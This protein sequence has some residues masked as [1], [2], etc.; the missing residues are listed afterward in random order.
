MTQ[1]AGGER[2]TGCGT[3]YYD[4]QCPLCSAEVRRLQQLGN[5]SLSLLD[6]HRLTDTGG[7]AEKT[8]LLKNLHYVTP[9]GEVLVGLDANVAAWQH[10]R[11][12]IL[13]RWL[14]WPFVRPVAVQLYAF[15]AKRRYRRLYE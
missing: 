13:W 3:L 9:S 8:D 10:T 6:I 4:G 2:A 11:V 14:R 1:Q 7:P 5:G 15:W 12:G